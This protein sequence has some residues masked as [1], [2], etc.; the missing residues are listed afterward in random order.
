MEFRIETDPPEVYRPPPWPAPRSDGGARRRVI[1]KDNVVE[2]EAAAEVED[3]A[4]LAWACGSESRPDG[5]AV[6]E[7]CVLHGHRGARVRLQDATQASGINDGP[8][9]MDG[10]RPGGSGDVQFP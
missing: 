4:T 8:V 10:H 1:V 5:L 3:T 2:R 9:S 6:R 7:L